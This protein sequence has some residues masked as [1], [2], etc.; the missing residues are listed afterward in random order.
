MKTIYQVQSKFRDGEWL[1]DHMPFD[2]R[3]QAVDYIESQYHG[4][5]Q[6]R[7]IEDEILEEEYLQHMLDMADDYASRE[8]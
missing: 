8:Y 5:Y 2:T 6:Y 7:I 1:D 4:N 3:E